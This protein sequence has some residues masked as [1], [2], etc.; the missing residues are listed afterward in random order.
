MLS[1]TTAFEAS[2]EQVMLTFLYFIYAQNLI[3]K[4]SGLIC[5]QTLIERRKQS[6]K[7]FYL[8]TTL[9]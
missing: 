9:T 6:E 3:P 7:A 2:S 1:V 4:L 8:D 5:E